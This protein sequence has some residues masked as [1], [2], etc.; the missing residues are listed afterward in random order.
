MTNKIKF[1]LPVLALSLLLSGTVALAQDTTTG[2][3]TGTTGTAVATRKACI[4]DAKAVRVA[5]VK[6]AK[7]TAKIISA[8]DP[9]DQ[10]A[11]VACYAAGTTD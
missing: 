9:D 3:N 1:I 7:T 10:V 2:A 6:T 4:A 5:A 11:G 8:T